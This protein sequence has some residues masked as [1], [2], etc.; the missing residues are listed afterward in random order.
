MKDSNK[1]KML[2]A[3][4]A[5]QLKTALL[6]IPQ[7]LSKEQKEMVQEAVAACEDRLDELEIDGLIARFKLLS[8]SNKK[9]FIKLASKHIG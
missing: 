4:D 5:L 9:R 1:I 8:K 7:V 3:N 6:P 2:S